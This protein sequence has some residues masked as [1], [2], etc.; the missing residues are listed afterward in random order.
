MAYVAPVITLKKNE[1]NQYVPADYASGGH[2]YAIV[3][4]CFVY[5]HLLEGFILTA[6]FYHMVVEIV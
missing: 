4:A 2:M 5:P 3:G 6:K 1:D